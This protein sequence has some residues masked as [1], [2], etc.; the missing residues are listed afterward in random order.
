MSP[1]MRQPVHVSLRHRAGSAHTRA[2]TQRAFEPDIEADRCED[3]GKQTGSA[4]SAIVGWRA[5]STRL[6]GACAHPSED[7][8]DY[9]FDDHG[10]AAKH[11]EAEAER[12][13]LCAHTMISCAPKQPG[14]SAAAAAAPPSHHGHGRNVLWIAPLPQTQRAVA[15]PAT[16]GNSQCVSGRTARSARSL[17]RTRGW[18]APARTAAAPPRR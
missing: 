17:V 2:H 16:T 8:P 12:S 9:A 11:P 18:A 5:G 6:R 1:T 10:G 15:Q 13:R 3:L 4:R 7:E 14:Q